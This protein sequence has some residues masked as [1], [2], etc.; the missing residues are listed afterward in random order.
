MHGT[1]IRGSVWD[2]FALRWRGAAP[3]KAEPIDIFKELD[4]ARKI[5]ILPN[6]RV[7]GVFIGA[8]IY[9]IVREVYPNAEIALLVDESKVAIA[10]HI[11]FVDKVISGSL[12]G[13]VWKSSFRQLANQ[14]VGEEL[15]IALCLGADCSFRLAQLCEASGA[16]LRIGFR[17]QDC[18]PYNIEIVPQS[19]DLYEGDQ[20]VNMLKILGLKGEGDIRWTIAQDLA[21]Q[22]RDRY[23]DSDFAR[24]HVVGID[25][26]RGEG[27]GLS[28]RQFEDIVGRVIERGARAVLFF[29]LAER[30]QVN[31][32][33]ETYGNRT[34][35]FEQ[36]DM[37][38]VAALI[39]GC[40]A[41]ISCNTDLLHMAIA[42]QTP[43]VGI[44]DEDSQR[45]ISQRNYS[46]KIVQTKDI[47]AISIT[48]IVDA[49]EE[50]LQREG[51]KK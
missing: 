49:L 1:W 34:L 29:T 30:K 45:W 8:P 38:G 35:L 7:G 12:H 42:L 21:C 33:K 6:D 4:L 28:S 40:T 3:G 14:L 46:G 22:I 31:Y 37:A 24:N 47:R 19:T 50:V 13:S 32:L 36:D 9:K 26:V 2:R 23:L 39:E 25:L 15:H 44:F 51:K 43:T 16:R 11:P 20:C 5:L 18:T 10:Q 48:D 27:R 17:R 41:L